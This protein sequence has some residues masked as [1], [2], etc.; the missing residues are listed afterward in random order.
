MDGEDADGP[1]VALQAEDGGVARLGAGLAHEPVEQ[2][3][4]IAARAAHAGM[5]ELGQVQQVGEGP[6]AAGSGRRHAGGEPGLPGEP[7]ERREEA[8]L[9][10]RVGQLAEE[11]EVLRHAAR[12]LRSA[13]RGG[14]RVDLRRVVEVRR[15]RDVAERRA[16]GPRRPR[17]EGEGGEQDGELQGDGRGL[18]R[19]AAGVVDHQ[20]AE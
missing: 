6:F 2:R 4:G 18:E 20:E 11:A 10:R 3:G 19:F 14:E 9:A 8:V 16:A 7:V 15:E 17:Q 5:D 1:A 12:L 13:L